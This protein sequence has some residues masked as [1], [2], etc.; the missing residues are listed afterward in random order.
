VP[1]GRG[2][3]YLNGISKPVDFVLG[4]WQLNG[5]L[6]W[7]AGQPFTPSYR[8]CNADRD[9]GWCRPDLIGDYHVSDPSQFGWFQT[10]A[11]PLTANG[12]I[13]G[14]WQR[15][16]RGRFGTVGRNAI[17]GPTFSQWDMSFFKT[18][19]FTERHQL[20]FRAESFNF[21]NRTNLANPNACVD[22][23]GVAGRIFGAYSSYVPRQWQF[24]LKFQY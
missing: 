17:V 23:P 18:F 24:A 8:D 14:P 19:A 5:T 7:M 6:S 1:F 16:L 20:Q 11:V 3:K 4:G 21:A 10:T 13:D 9:T 15:P 2:R 22:C 12:Q